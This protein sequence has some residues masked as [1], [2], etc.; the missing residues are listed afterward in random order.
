MFK[1]KFN[2]LSIEGIH[3]ALNQEMGD[4][5]IFPSM[6]GRPPMVMP[7]SAEDFEKVFRNEDQYPYRRL[8]DT[9]QY[10]RETVRPDVYSEFGSLLTENDESWYKTRT[11][12]NPIMLKPQ[13]IK[14]YVP[15]V[16]EIAKDFVQL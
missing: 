2:G 9:L 4:I 5:T 1:G 8:L 11:L 13:T 7:F 3:K 14:L 16:D 10:Y 12:V 15:Q 6:F